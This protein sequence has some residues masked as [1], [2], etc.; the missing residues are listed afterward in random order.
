MG[1]VIILVPLSVFVLAALGLARRVIA[2]PPVLRRETPG[3]EPE[4]RVMLARRWMSNGGRWRRP[5]SALRLAA[6]RWGHAAIYE[7]GA[8][9][10]P[11]S[12]SVPRRAIVAGHAPPAA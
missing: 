6:R 1:A 3:C 5:S 8:G 12:T 10:S 7:R 9:P 11:P 2:E 4:V